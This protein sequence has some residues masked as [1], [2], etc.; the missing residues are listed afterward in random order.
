MIRLKVITLAFLAVYAAM[1]LATI[2][3][4]LAAA[5]ISW[6]LSWFDDKTITVLLIIFR[7]EV[8]MAAFMALLLGFNPDIIQAAHEN[9]KAKDILKAKRKML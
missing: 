7:I 3:Y 5:F 8:I 2:A 4:P 1:V 6:N 9:Q